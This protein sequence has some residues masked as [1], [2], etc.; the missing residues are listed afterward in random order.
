MRR[1]RVLT[2]FLLLVACAPASAAT[3]VLFI[4]NG[5]TYVGN[6]PA[7]FA[8]LAAANGRRVESHMLVK[9]GATLSDRVIDGSAE[10]ALARGRYDYVILQERAGDFVC[11]LPDDPVCA[12]SNAALAAMTKLAQAHAARAIVLGTYLC[13]SERVSARF[14]QAEATAT[15][16]AQLA[17]VAVAAPLQAGRAARPARPWCSDRTHA[18][19]DAVLLAAAALFREVFG[20]LPA[21]VKVTVTAPIFPPTTRFDIKVRPAVKAQANVPFGRRYSAADVSQVVDLLR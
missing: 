12:Q 9:S 3:R 6:V 18:G 11:E 14:A 4:G 13:E 10:R 19:S 16:D 5:H 8:A 1:L 21:A 17:Y 20:E 2:V 7:V 15:T